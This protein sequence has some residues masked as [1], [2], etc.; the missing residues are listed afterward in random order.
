LV[1]DLRGSFNGYTNNMPATIDGLASPSPVEINRPDFTG[2]VDG[3]FDVDRDLKLTS[4]FRLRLATDNPGSPNVQAGLQKYPIYA[5]YG[6][7]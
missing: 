2:H 3:R 4:Q 1:A 7:T 6:G 5:T